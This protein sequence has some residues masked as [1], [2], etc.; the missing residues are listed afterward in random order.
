MI[1]RNIKIIPD[2]DESILAMLTTKIWVSKQVDDEPDIMVDF[3]D[4]L[5]NNLVTRDGKVI[6]VFNEKYRLISYNKVLII[7]G[8]KT[9]EHNKQIFYITQGHS[10]D[11][12]IPSIDE[13]DRYPKSIFTTSNE[14]KIRVEDFNKETNEAKSIKEIVESLTLYQSQVDYINNLLGNTSSH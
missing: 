11:H 9:K 1:P 7:N 6:E 12:L 4:P 10:K 8:L 5:L 13:T 14:V 2:T 3:N